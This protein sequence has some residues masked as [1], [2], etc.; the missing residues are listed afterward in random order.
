M[1]TGGPGVTYPMRFTVTPGHRVRP[2][3]SGEALLARRAAAV[4]LNGAAVT[5][6]ACTEGNK[7]RGPLY[8]A[9]FL[10]RSHTVL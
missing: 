7:K 10:H 1:Q 5:L 9:A 2:C 3:R 4:Q 8:I 6:Q